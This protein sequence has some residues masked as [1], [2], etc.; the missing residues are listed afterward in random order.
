MLHAYLSSSNKSVEISTSADDSST[1]SGLF[2]KNKGG[3]GGGKICPWDGD[4]TRLSKIFFKNNKFYTKN[5]IPFIIFGFFGGG[6]GTE[7][8][9]VDIATGNEAKFFVICE[10]NGG[11]C[12]GFTEFSIKL[13]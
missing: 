4:D 12:V 2:F 13:I 3:G 6:G 8:I 11:D 1:I 7:V 10:D 9:D 5:L